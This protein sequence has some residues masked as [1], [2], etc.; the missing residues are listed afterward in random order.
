MSEFFSYRLGPLSNIRDLEY[1]RLGF[2]HY[3]AVVDSQGQ[4]LYNWKSGEFAEKQKMDVSNIVQI[5]SATVESCRD[6]VML[7][8]ISETGS[9]NLY[10]FNGE[11]EVF[12]KA[13]S[14]NGTVV[15]SNFKIINISKIVQRRVGNM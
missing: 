13:D 9:M 14:G 12:Q 2:H 8:M 3:L 5:Y 15:C 11:N 7:L 10:V 4:I 1:F 6:E